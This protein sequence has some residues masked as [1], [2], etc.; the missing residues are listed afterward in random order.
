MSASVPPDARQWSVV[1]V[2][3]DERVVLDDQT[4]SDLDE[5]S[6]S[7]DIVCASGHRYTAE[8]AGLPV[9][10]L[11]DLVGAP[12]DTTHLSVE[13]RD[14]YRIAIPIAAGLNGLLALWKDGEPIGA[15]NPYPNRFV[16]RGIEGA[17]DVKGVSKIEFHALGP[18][19]DPDALEVVEP[20]DDRFASDRDDDQTQ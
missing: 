9:A 3:G 18:G 13:S 15:S 12:V 8:W 17:R 10:A 7:V 1:V 11:V 19:D 16:A 2:S 5:E 4:V 14:G 6:T 20:V